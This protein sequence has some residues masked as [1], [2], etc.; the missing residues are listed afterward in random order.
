MRKITK[1][2]VGAFARGIVDRVDNTESTGTQ[3]WLFGKLIAEW[4]GTDLW[5]TTAGYDTNTTRDRLNGIPGVQVYH[6]KRG[7][8]FLNGQPWDGD[9]I[10]VDRS[11]D[12]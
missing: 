12:S 11:A 10:E 5:V 1:R 4:R 9:W 7:I 8:L 6:R 2:V 3:L